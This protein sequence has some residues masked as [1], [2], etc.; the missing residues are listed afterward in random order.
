MIDVSVNDLREKLTLE[1]PQ[2]SPDTGGG[3]TIT[4]VK[5]TDLWAH[6]LPLRTSENFKNHQTKN[7]ITHRI[8]IR[9][10]EGVLPDMR[11]TKGERIFQ[12][13]GVMNEKERRQWLQ[14]DVSEQCL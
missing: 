3:T 14:L 7:T 10:R 6:I 5:I 9:Y 11:L 1:Q 4:F 12:I 8:T 13:L 2:L